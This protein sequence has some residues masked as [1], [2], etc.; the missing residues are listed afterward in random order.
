MLKAHNFRNTRKWFFGIPANFSPRSQPRFY[1][2][3]QNNHA[4]GTNGLNGARLFTLVSKD[5]RVFVGS[6]HTTNFVGTNTLGSLLLNSRSFSYSERRAEAPKGTGEKTENE[7]APS[8]K[9]K[10]LTLWEKVKHEANHYWDGTKLFG[11]ELKIS[12]KLFAKMIS[13]RSLTRREQRQLKRTL[14]DL[15]RLVPFSLFVIVPFAE[16]LLPFALKIFP[17][18]LPSPYEDKATKEKKKKKAM[19]TRASVSRY[20]RETINEG[21][22]LKKKNLLEGQSN[23]PELKTNA[24]A[25]E[26][27]LTR[28]RSSGGHVEPKDIVEL[29]SIFKDDLTLD[30]LTRPQ[31]VSICRY[32]D[33][34]SFGTDNYL[35]Y[36]IRKRMNYIKADDQVISSE[37][38]DTLTVSELQGA[39]IARGIRTTGIS[40]AKMRD[41][42]EYWIKLHLVYET[43]STILILSR[44]LSASDSK[45][46][47]SMDVLQT[48]LSSLPESLVNEATLT[49]AE[50]QGTATNKQ[51]LDVLEEQEELIE[52]ETEQEE[53]RAESIEN[54]HPDKQQPPTS[55]PENSEQL[56]K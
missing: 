39:C 18:L 40:P 36:Q 29:V 50:Q 48:T 23:S 6:K 49:I 46:R 55:N 43:P 31:L 44:I 41:E 26:K 47:P 2:T 54:D 10:K 25:V 38:I 3:Q 52:D 20:L 7:I 34:Q 8:P 1:I 12:T 21:I 27:L 28:I 9:E 22:E 5:K 30:N 14:I 42:L 35:K 13:G 53:R 37:G 24:E 19:E 45:V 16:L 33:I 11:K 17:N 15:I 32:L 56:K 51:R 4:F